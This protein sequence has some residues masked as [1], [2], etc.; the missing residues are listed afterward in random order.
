[1]TERD[2]KLVIN[3]ARCGSPTAASAISPSL[4]AL[5]AIPPRR[6]AKARRAVSLCNAK[7]RST[8]R[9]IPCVGL[10]QGHLAELLFDDVG[11]PANNALGATGDAARV[12]TVTWNVN[13][14]LMG[15][16]AIYL[17]Q[18][19]LDAAV[20]YAG[21]RKQFGR[22]ISGKQLVQGRLISR[23]RSRPAGCCA[24]RR[25]RKS[26]AVFAATG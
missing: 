25:W 13:R 10:Q 16:S 1:V 3:T 2:G 14:P 19:A 12:L 23:R 9:E 6:P 24:T 8:K 20:A 5:M 22:L 7:H 26:I 21:M 18:R 17:A 4:P 11:V 15:L